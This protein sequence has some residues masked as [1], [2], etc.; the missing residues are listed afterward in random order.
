MKLVKAI[1]RPERLEALK[2][3]LEENGFS[4]MTITGVRGRGEQS[5]IVLEYRGG[6]MM[7][8]LIPKIQVELVVNYYK[9]DHL[10][11]LIMDSCRTGNLG[12][13]KIF[14]LPAENAMCIR[15]IES[16]KES[17]AY[18]TTGSGLYPLSDLKPIEE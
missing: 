15:T 7:V 3:T 4:G 6:L 12:D 9:V 10:V 1:I 11:T 14:V 2:K 17:P 13:G 5:R 16:L 8:G 18:G